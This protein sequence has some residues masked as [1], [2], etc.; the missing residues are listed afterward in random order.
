MRKNYYAPIR[1][2]ADGSIY[3]ERNSLLTEF[4]SGAAAIALFTALFTA[5]VM[6]ALVDPSGVEAERHA[7]TTRPGEIVSERGGFAL[8]NGR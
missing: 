1:R 5:I 8:Q 6:F 3:L 4:L 2:R 7:N